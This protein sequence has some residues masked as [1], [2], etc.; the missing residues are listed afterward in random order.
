MGFQKMPFRESS[1]QK[2]RKGLLPKS[3]MH[4]I[5]PFAILQREGKL[6]FLSVMMNNM[7][8]N[9]LIK[10][11]YKFP[12]MLFFIETKKGSNGR[13]GILFI[14]IVIALLRPF[15]AR[16]FSIYT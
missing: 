4:S 11:T 6:L 3:C 16:R 9:F 2:W 14:E 13:S 1:L 12:G 15:L 7:F 10:N 5:N 8:L